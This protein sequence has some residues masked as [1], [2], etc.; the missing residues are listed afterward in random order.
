MQNRDL[1]TVLR[2]CEPK[3]RKRAEVSSMRINNQKGTCSTHKNFVKKQLLQTV[4]YSESIVH[5]AVVH[6]A[7]FVLFEVRCRCFAVC[8]GR[9]RH[10]NN[11]TIRWFHNEVTANALERETVRVSAVLHIANLS[12]R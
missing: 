4:L 9:Q 1:S 11:I 3:N 6:F 5:F 8:N 2:F 7:V 12:Q 10:G